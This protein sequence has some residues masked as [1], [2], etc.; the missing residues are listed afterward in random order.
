M[1][2]SLFMIWLCLVGLF[3]ACITPP[4]EGLPG[5]VIHFDQ[6]KNDHHFT[7]D[8]DCLSAILQKRSH[9]DTTDIQFSA[10]AYTFRRTVILDSLKGHLKFSGMKGTVFQ[11]HQSLLRLQ[12]DKCPLLLQQDLRRHDDVIRITNPC[13]GIALV[14]VKSEQAV[15]TAWN[16]KAIDLLS[17]ETQELN[18]LKSNDSLNFSYKKENCEVDGY[19]S[20][21]LSCSHITF[22]HQG[23]NFSMMSLTGLKINF[24]DCSFINKGVEEVGAFL[25]IYNCAPIQLLRTILEGNVNYG[26]LINASRDVYIRDMVSKGPVHPIAPATWTTNVFVEDLYCEGSV[27]D[28]HPSFHVTYKDVTVENGIGYWNCRA[29]GVKLENCTLDV[30]DSYKDASLYLGVVALADEF[31]F[32]NNEYDVICKNVTWLHQDM[33]F[34][35]LHVHKCRDFKVD[36]CTTHAV[37]TGDKI[38]TFRVTDSHIGRLYC[39][40]SNFEVSRT[41]FDGTLQHRTTTVPPLSCSYDGHIKIDSCRFEHYEDTYLFNYIQ[42][43]ATKVDIRNSSLSGVK[44]FARTAYQPP[45]TYGQIKFENTQLN[46][47]T[48]SALSPYSNIKYSAP[49]E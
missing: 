7:S 43:T 21:S 29:L 32:L 33:D 2:T 36:N 9:L 48:K 18:Q 22:L 13:P 37:S 3:C 39:S 14:R 44:G 6:V 1:R 31:A 47:S 24:E 42:S 25:N 38:R 40:D 17:V 35:G 16:Y 15:E 26:V 30:V 45:Q 4:M 20:A 19:A 5:K 12:A 27:I 49:G 10:R 8:D 11:L 46:T 34:N 41:V 23:P 28:A